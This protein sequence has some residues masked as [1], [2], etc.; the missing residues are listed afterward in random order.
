MR[1]NEI[2]IAATLA[3]TP[4]A[5]YSLG[6][7]ENPAVG[8]TESGIGVISGWHCSAKKIDLLLDGEPIGSAFVGSTR[9]D[10]TNICGGKFDTGFSFLINFNE[11]TRG[12]HSIKALANGVTF[13][14]SNFNSTKSGGVGFLTGVKKQVTVSDFPSPGSNATLAWNQSKQSFVVIGTQTGSSSPNPTTATGL[15]KLY[16]NVTFSYKFTSSTQIYT[17]STNFSAA[18]LNSDGNLTGAIRNGSGIIL[19]GE[20]HSSPEFV[21]VLFNKAGTAGIDGFLFDV[22]STGSIFGAYEY[23]P[24]TETSATCATEL[25]RTPDGI[26]SG[27]VSRVTGASISAKALNSGS[28]G[29]K[30]E[31]KLTQQAIEADEASHARLPSDQSEALGEML[32]AA[33]RMIEK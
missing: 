19:C 24:A 27:T 10:T 28:S 9:I 7:L 13:A 26:V 25:T 5:G 33:R 17:D 6:A 22:S 15:A 2:L 23:C 1:L 20:T 29:D 21:C 30:F 3:A 12:S 4:V 14:E 8:T 18:S 11:L 32:D 16:G 31:G